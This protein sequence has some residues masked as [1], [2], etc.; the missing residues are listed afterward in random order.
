M[1]EQW[2]ANRVP[3]IDALHSGSYQQSVNYL[4]QKGVMAGD[5]NLGVVPLY[6]IGGMMCEIYRQHHPLFLG[7]RN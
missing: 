2:R 5:Y 1:T 3:L 4:R 6:C 7:G